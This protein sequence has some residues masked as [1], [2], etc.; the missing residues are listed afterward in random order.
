M[1]LAPKRAS[2]RLD[3]V[4]GISF[5]FRRS[6]NTEKPA[7]GRCRMFLMNQ[8]YAAALPSELTSKP[9]ARTICGEVV[10]MYR[11]A[12]GQ[13]VALADRCP[14]RYAPLSAG[15]CAGDNIVC[16][17]HGLVFDPT[18][19]CARIPHQPTIPQKMRVRAFPLVERW[20]WAWIWMGDASRADPELIP[21]YEWLQ[22]VPVIVVHTSMPEI[23]HTFG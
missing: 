7:P 8:W 5:N 15:T 9:I 4:G 23:A 2:P 22:H 3:L 13:P 21:A 17:Y 18:G 14:H 20:G 1:Q 10:V 16:R 12:S 11:T 19:A 6:P